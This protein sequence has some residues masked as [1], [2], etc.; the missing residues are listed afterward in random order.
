[1]KQEK[2][3]LII[4]TIEK[5]QTI[6]TRIYGLLSSSEEELNF[7]L[8]QLLKKYDCED[9]ISTLYTCVKEITLN[10]TKA[11]IKRVLFNELRVDLQ[12]ENQ[13]EEG[14]KQFKAKLT[15]EFIFDYA[16]KAKKMNLYVDIRFEYDENRIL[17]EV[18]NNSPLTAQEDER[19]RAKF[20]TSS[21]YNDLAEFYMDNA[22]N[23]EGAGLGITL[24]LMLLKA[25]GYDPTLFRIFS[26]RKTKT[27]AKLEF[28]ISEN[29]KPERY[30]FAE[31]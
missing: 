23:T 27:V 5:S 1:M 29:Y 3:D 13:Y 31:T 26:D 2:K 9:K 18:I 7:I 20:E 24:I 22:D 16:V 21:K 14:M 19:I 17:I 8:E 4:S 12:D 6:R 30:R 11:N 15:E 25:D 10:G 28:P